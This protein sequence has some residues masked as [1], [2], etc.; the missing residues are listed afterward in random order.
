MRWSP[1]DGPG[2]SE[3]GPSETEDGPTETEDGSRED[4]ETPLPAAGLDAVAER[5]V[6]RGASGFVHVAEDDADRRYLTRIAAPNRETAVVVVPPAAAAA[7]PIEVVYCLPAT[8]TAVARAFLAGDVDSDGNDID[9]N[10]DGSD[11]NGVDTDRNDIGTDESD[12]D[13]NE[14]DVDIGT[15]GNDARA[16]S[17]RLNRRVAFRSPGTTAGSHAVAVLGER[18]AS[19]G[20]GSL[21]VPRRIPHDA[22]LELTA[23][24]YTLQ[25][26][27]ALAEARARKSPAERARLESLQRMAARGLNRGVSLLA[28]SDAIEG[29]AQYEGRPLSASRVEAEMRVALAHAG[30]TPDSVAIKVESGGLSPDRHAESADG[31][32]AGEPLVLHVRVRGAHGYH[33]RLTRTV[34]LDSDGGWDRRA[35]IACAAGLDAGLRHCRAETGV[36]TVRAE[37]VAELAAYGFEPVEG[38]RIDGPVEAVGPDVGASARVHGIGLDPRERPS[39]ED[40]GVL[41]ADSVVV[42]ETSVADIDYGRIRLGT[43]AAVEDDGARELLEYPTAVTPAAIQSARRDRA[44]D[45]STRD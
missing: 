38:P 28:A 31:L 10:E 34:V 24:G 36:N 19:A 3:D 9:S 29:H 39:S 32:P 22:A 17:K 33:G 1:G 16:T 14:S 26:T 6:E 13:T 20:T 7:D 42:I 45:E 12:V 25:S 41:R 2:E 23:A 35:N 4:V 11:E 44:D 37:A 30:V 8:S 43:V 15:H 40:G 5:V 21:L 27:T 18:L